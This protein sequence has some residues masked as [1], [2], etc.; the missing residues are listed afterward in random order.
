MLLIGKL[1]EVLALWWLMEVIVLLEGEDTTPA[2]TTTAPWA[3]DTATP[4][5]AKAAPWAGELA[6]PAM[7]RLVQLVEENPISHLEEQAL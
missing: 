4:A 7:D 2:A 1:C 3:G 6:T 5:A